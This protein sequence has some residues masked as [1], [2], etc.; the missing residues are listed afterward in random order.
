MNKPTVGVKLPVSGVG[1][2]VFSGSAVVEFVGVIVLT[3][4]AVAVATG[5]LVI[6]GVA[7]GVDT[8]AGPSDA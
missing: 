5:V 2:I 8:K 3:A 7:D 6:N 4:L 1:F